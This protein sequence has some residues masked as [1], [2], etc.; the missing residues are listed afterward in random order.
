MS[1]TLPFLHGPAFF[2]PPSR[3][4]VVISWRE[5]RCRY[6]MRLGYTVKGALLLKIKELVPGIWAKGCVFDDCVS[7]IWLD[8]TTNPW[9]KWRLWCI[10]RLINL[11]SLIYNLHREMCETSCQQFYK[12]ELLATGRW[13]CIN[14]ARLVFH[15]CVIIYIVQYIVQCYRIHYTVY[16]PV[17]P[18]TLYTTVLSFCVIIYIVHCIVLCYRI[19]YTVYSSV[20]SYILW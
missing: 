14:N 9:W 11:H 15:L 12:N 13:Q 4:L 7:V 18:Y 19:H 1:L 2:G 6:M 8:M 5:V 16:S 17:L 10:L 3:A 20:L